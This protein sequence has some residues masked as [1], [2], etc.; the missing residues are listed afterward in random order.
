MPHIPH[1][2]KCD[3]CRERDS[4]KK[5]PLKGCERC[6]KINSD[7]K[8]KNKQAIVEHCYNVIYKNWNATYS[9]V[10]KE[11]PEKTDSVIRASVCEIITKNYYD[12]TATDL[13][14]ETWLKSIWDKA[15]ED[16]NKKLAETYQA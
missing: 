10:K 4:K 1:K 15:L 5:D 14:S 3:E 12:L 2:V 9:Q 6:K 16:L 7:K 8:K 11:N 13:C